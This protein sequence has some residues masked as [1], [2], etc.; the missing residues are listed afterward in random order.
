MIAMFLL[1]RNFIRHAVEWKLGIYR[2]Y[3]PLCA[4]VY[5]TFRCNLACV[6]CNDGSGKKYPDCDSD[7]ELSTDQWLRVLSVIR[8]ETD[9][10]IF[11]GG[12]PTMRKDLKPILDGCRSLGF[13]KICL[14]TNGVTLERHP[15]ILETCHILMVSLDTLDEARSDRMM[16]A[17]AGTFRR[18]MKNVELACEARKSH[19][20]RLYFNVVVTPDNVADVHD[21]ID[22]CLERSIGFTP[23]P[24][25]V[26]FY[27]RE[28]LKG[29][30]DYEALIDRMVELKRS[31]C[32]VLG[33]MGYIRGVKRFDSYRCLAPLLA[34]VWPNGDLCYPCQKLHKVGG[35]LLALGDYSK[36]VDEGVARHG[37]IPECDNRC[38]VGCYMDFSM[39]IQRPGLL[40]EE[41]WYGLKRP[42]FDARQHLRGASTRGQ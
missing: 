16:G 37:P 20:I 21:V 33:T 30:P 23:L 27:P 22:F 29:N 35:N 42:F 28:G 8:R 41:A 15:E 39:C 13:A 38:H 1:E 24:E 11:T 31:G 18:I 7:G 3:R 14:L 9:V 36:A 4:Y 5:L 17:P 12:E 40:L 25:V 10:L 2:P 19:G 32:E 34:R 26:G 6:Y